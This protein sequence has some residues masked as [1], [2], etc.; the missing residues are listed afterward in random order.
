MLNPAE[1]RFTSGADVNA[2]LDRWAARHLDDPDRWSDV[3]GATRAWTDYSTRNALLLASYGADGPVAGT[4]TWRLVPS[5]RDRPCAV[6]TGEHGL[7]VRVPIT[8]PGHEPDPTFGGQRRTAVA[9][10]DWEWRPVF[11]V[12]QLVRRPAPGALTSVDLPRDLFGTDGHAEFVRLARTVAG[13]MIRGHPPRSDDPHAILAAAAGHHPRSG[14]RPILDAD[15]AGQVAWLVADRVGHAT[16]PMPTFDPGPLRARERWERLADVLE[17]TRRMIGV[18]G[19]QARVDLLRSPLPRM[20]IDEDGATH[21]PRRN[22]L[23]RAS[24]DRLPVGRWVDVGPYSDQE[25]ETRGEHGS[26]RGAYL[27]LNTTAYLTVIER[28]DTAAWRIEDLR[29]PVGVGLLAKGPA[30]SFDDAKATATAALRDRYPQLATVTA[31]HPH[32]APERVHPSNPRWAPLDLG[33]GP[34]AEHRQLTNRTDLYVVPLDNG[35]WL[36]MTRTTGPTNQLTPL[37]EAS[38]RQEARDRAELAG[39][40]ADRHAGHAPD[41]DLDEAVTTLAAHDSY[42]RTNLIA[43]IGSRLDP[44]RRDRLAED[45]PASELTDL[46]QAAGLNP[47]TAVAVLAAEQVEP[48]TAAGLI[49][50]IGLANPEAILALHLHWQVPKA[51]AAELLGADAADMRAANCDASEIL[52]VRPGPLLAAL[53]TDPETWDLAG[54]TMTTVGHSA[55]DVVAHLATHA[56]NA[57]CFAAGVAAA[58]DDPTTA[59]RLAARFGIP[60]EGVVATSERYGLSPLETANA[61]G[62]SGAST[63]LTVATLLAR[64]DGDATLT[65]QLARSALGLRTSD[66]LDAF[67]KL[68]LPDPPDR[69]ADL[70]QVRPLSKDPHALVAANQPP[71]VSVNRPVATTDSETLLAALPQPNGDAADTTLLDRIPEADTDNA[72]REQPG[73]TSARVVELR[74]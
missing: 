62:N 60:V 50:V 15:L 35:A 51:T 37:P 39:R 19:D 9:I 53:P 29:S 22:R 11:C 34:T 41:V 23:T 71:R 33:H 4:E 24:L 31:L 70:S 27:R 59:L 38:S 57:D 30:D 26:G 20:T 69:D 21:G 42:D 17:P 36:P 74:R 52:A 40:Q 8:G 18:L 72:P 65:T 14:R 7:P 67:D 61:L 54:G 6:A 63:D 43:L 47:Q 45:I 48:A 58:I 3:L 16:G 68:G 64:C 13:R 55:Q 1:I 73:P 5:T 46:L 12:E 25:W 32:P 56:P 49:P 44:E 66:L 28:G 10:R 2:H